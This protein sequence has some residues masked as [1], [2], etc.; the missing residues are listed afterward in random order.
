MVLRACSLTGLTYFAKRVDHFERWLWRVAKRNRSNVSVP[1]ICGAAGPVVLLS[2]SRVICSHATR[3]F[4]D[5]LAASTFVSQAA[6]LRDS[7]TSAA[8]NAHQ[9]Q[10][11]CIVK[12]LSERFQ[13]WGASD[14]GELV[15]Q[16]KAQ[17]AC[18]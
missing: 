12:S 5:V 15:T 8:S 6:C 17:D 10:K 18:T 7:A 3:C 13:R 2:T 11:W 1:R 9:V 4:C 16:P 14:R